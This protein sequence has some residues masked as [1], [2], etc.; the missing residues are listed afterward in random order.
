MSTDPEEYERVCRVCGVGE[1]ECSC[2]EC[3][4]CHGT[5]WDYEENDECWHCDGYGVVN[6]ARSN[7]LT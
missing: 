1:S 2:E 6:I 4:E 5:G 7:G 3:F